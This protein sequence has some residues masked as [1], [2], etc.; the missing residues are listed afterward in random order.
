MTETD[1]LAVSVGALVRFCCRSGDI[2]HRLRPSSTAQEGS[3]GHQRIYRRRPASYLPEYSVSYQSRLEGLPL[4]LRGRADGYDPEQGLVEEIKTCRVEPGTLPEALTRSH[5]AQGR[6]YAALIAREQGLEGLLVRLTWLHLDE[7]REYPLEQYYCRA[8]LDDFL[9]QTLSRFAR[10]LTRLAAHRQERDESVAALPFPHADFRPGQR[11]LAERVYKCSARGGQ[12][13]LEAPTGIGKTAAVLYPALKAQG[14]GKFQR[15]VF[16]TAKNA[17]RRAAQQAFERFRERGYRGQALTL[18]AKDDLCLSP[19]SACHGDDCPYA[20]GY[21]DRLPDAMVAA[22]AQPSLDRD[23][24]QALAREFQ[25]CPWEL[26]ADLLPWIDTVI[27]DIHYLYSFNATIAGNDEAAGR[28][29]VLLDEA[30]NLPSRAVSLY[31]ARLDK[32]ALMAVKRN[33]PKGDIRRALDRINRQL[34]TLDKLAW[35]EADWHQLTEIPAELLVAMQ[36]F[37]ADVGEQ[38]A[39]QPV[40]LVRIAGLMNFYF[41]ALQWLR[42]AEAWGDDYRCE[43]LRGTARGDFAVRLICLDPTRLLAQRQSALH[44]VVA[45]SATLSPWEWARDSLGLR[46]DTVCY[47]AESPF[48]ADQLQVDVVTDIDTRF[49]QRQQSL[50]QLVELLGNWLRHESGN[51]LLYFPSYQYLQSCLALLGD[52]PGR[53][54]CIQNPGGGSRERDAVLEALETRRNVAAFCVLGGAFGEGIDLPGERLS[55]V[56]IVGVGLPRL[57]RETEARQALFEAKYGQGF[58]YAFVYPGMQKVA[59]ALGRVIRDNA[60]TGRAL[61]VDT[62]YS[63]L[64]YRDLLPPWWTYRVRRAQEVVRTE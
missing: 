56:V 18:N 60:D 14:Q 54:L 12:L 48:S 30:H 1:Q 21:Y 9:E 4:L 3:E 10:W 26:S 52:M 36:R 23:S 34:L 64:Q 2:D 35:Q 45:F 39:R 6:I 59:Q 38:L 28:A 43:L 8:E 27:A 50:P 29:A 61:I 13:L 5:L 22:L 44:A 42:A 20:R 40:A 41:D 17:G 63:Q 37:A 19:G 51:C 33:L 62:R 31:S 58:N 11:E 25:I 47:R 49:R 32:R 55:S 53:Y 15:L 57:E 7:D 46:S 16:C 24:L